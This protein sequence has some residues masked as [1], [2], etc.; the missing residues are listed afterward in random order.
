VSVVRKA[1][2]TAAGRGTRQFPATVTVQK[3]FIPLV[4]RDLVTKP[5]VQIVVEEAVASGIEEVCIVTSPE[6]L[7]QFRRHF[8]PVSA[9]DRA[10]FKGK[11]WALAETDHLEDLSDRIS[12]A[13]QE[14]PEGFGHAVYC[15]RDFVGDEPFLQMLGDHIYLPRG[16]VRCARQLLDA[17][18]QAQC[19]VTGVQQ[20]PTE[21]LHLFGTVAGHRRP[22][23]TPLYDV[24]AIVE[25]PTPEYAAEY[26]VTEGLPAGT[27]LCHFGMHVLTPGIFARLQERIERN[28]R[29]GGEIQLTS[30]QADLVTHEPY[31][32]LEVAGLRLDMGVPLG[33]LET[34]FALALAS[35]AREGLLARLKPFLVP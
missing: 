18:Q 2:I 29:E 21:E 20:T 16:E 30:A 7:C 32:A 10:A 15:A 23:L 8:G 11:A 5:T 24:T 22:G 4:D 6:G 3:E 34:Q 28:L 9:A 1:V 25:K 26:L 27:Y 31:T 13:L 17:Y 35:P 12:Y 19:T 14:T 33:L